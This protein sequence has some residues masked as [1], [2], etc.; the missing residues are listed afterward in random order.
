M[1]HIIRVLLIMVLFWAFVNY[2]EAHEKQPGVEHRK[3]VVGILFQTKYVTPAR[4]VHY[5]KPKMKIFR[6]WF[7]CIT[8][9]FERNN[10]K[11]DDS[12][13]FFCVE[14]ESSGNTSFVCCWLLLNIE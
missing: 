7:L 5:K 10:Q 12:V 1:K 2:V 3:I 13:Y 9:A 6:T 8:E 11:N 4:V 14:G